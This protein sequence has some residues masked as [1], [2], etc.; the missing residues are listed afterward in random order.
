[1]LKVAP[2][3]TE[4]IPEENVLI[5][6][7]IDSIRDIKGKRIVL[8]DVRHLH[9]APTDYFI[10]CEGESSTQVRAIADHISVRVKKELDTA[11]NHKEGIQ[12]ARWILVDYFD[13]VVH[14]FY[15]EARAY[16]DLEDFWS[17]ANIYNYEE[18]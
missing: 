8:L 16:Y 3:S 6:T 9:E 14:V 4:I 12:E 7:I 2:A 10:I 13:L 1:N 5:E 11:P 18:Q 17:D 15:P